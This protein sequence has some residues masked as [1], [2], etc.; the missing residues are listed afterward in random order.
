[1]GLPY[2]TAAALRDEEQRR[3]HADAEAAAREAIAEREL[4]ELT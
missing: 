3:A 2:L 1:V 4:D